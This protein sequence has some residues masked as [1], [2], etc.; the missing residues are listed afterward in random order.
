MKNLR[1]GGAPTEIRTERLL[2]TS[3][4]LYQ[5]TIPF[6]VLVSIGQKFASASVFILFL[7]IK[8]VTQIK[9]PG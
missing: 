5:W 4:E 1:I 7:Y 3:E 9:E 8:L 6:S 2:H